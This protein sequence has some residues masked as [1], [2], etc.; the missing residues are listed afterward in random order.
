MDQ[1]SRD[2]FPTRKTGLGRSLRHPV[3]LA[4]L[5]GQLCL[6]LAF[7]TPAYLLLPFPSAAADE[8]LEYQVKAAFLL[9]F[10]KFTEWP[11]AA[12]EE[13][14][15]PLA[16][17]ILGDDPFGRTLDQIVEG[18]VVDGHKIIVQ[19]IK[20]A[21]APKSCEVLFM[22]KPGKETGGILP[23]LGPGVLTVGEGDAFMRDG[24]MIA[25]VIEDRRVRFRANQSAAESAGLKLSSKLLSIAKSSKE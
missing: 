2:R 13:S 9:N 5:L 12:F 11:P 24:G 15:S 14:T 22:S 20:R 16:I 7:L 18:E 10:I 19:R 4:C 3:T 17:C 21:P 1:V 8:S 6:S 25:F 23:A